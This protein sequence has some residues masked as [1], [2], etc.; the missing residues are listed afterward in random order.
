M[1]KFLPIIL[2]VVGLL[3]LGGVF[4]VIK[5]K[6]SSTPEDEEANLLE[7]P[8]EERPFTTLTPKEDGHYLNLVIE[9][10][11]VADAKKVDYELVYK[12]PDGRAQGVPGTVEITGAKIER[13]LLLGS[14]SSGK[15]R[16][17][18][19][20][21]EGSLS[22]RFR[23]EK[24]KL[25]GKLSTD[26]HLQKDPDEITSMDGGLKYKLDKPVKNVFFV[27][28]DTFG[29]PKMVQGVHQGPTAILPSKVGPYPGMLTFSDNNLRFDGTD[30]KQVEDGK[31][32]DV[33]IFVGADNT[34]PGS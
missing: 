18:E 20:V 21:A 10:I 14:E 25:I 6:G 23:N 3:V 1:K 4:L 15:F 31:S 34:A 26:F 30:F 22:L 17:D 24:G 33:G 16:Y 13:P 9:G 29:L 28:M 2:V 11:K 12:L 7:I 32:S 5:G 27:T 19:G 8:L